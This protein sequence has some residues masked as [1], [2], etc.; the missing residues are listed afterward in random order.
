MCVYADESK[1][2]KSDIFKK[3]YRILPLTYY[4]LWYI[5]KK[6][7]MKRVALIGLGP[8]ARRIY[9]PYL[10][11]RTELG[12]TELALL[13][14]LE[15]NREAIEEYLSEKDLKPQRILFLDTVGQLEPKEVDDQVTKLFKKLKITHAIISTEPKAHKAYLE[16]CIKNKIPVIVDKP[17]VT[18]SNLMSNPQ[19]D[20]K[21]SSYEAAIQI[22]DEVDELY[23][24]IQRNPG[25]RVIVQCQRRQ[26]EGYELVREKLNE[27]V[28]AYNIPISYINIHH[29]DGMWNMPN[30]LY[31]R[32]NHPYKYGYGKIMHSG[33]HFIDLLYGFLNINMQLKDKLPDTINIFNQMLRPIDHYSIVNS[34][35]YENLLGKGQYSLPSNKREGDYMSYGELDSYGQLQLRKEGKV[36][37]TV[38]ISLMQSGFS[39]RAWSTL[40]KDTYKSNGRVRHE[41]VNIHIGPLFNI[42][43]HSYQAV[44]NNE[45]HADSK[46]IGGKDHFDIYIFRNT[47]LIG[48][49][50]F[51][52]IEFGHDEAEEYKKDAYYLGH[53]EKSRYQAVDELLDDLP[54]DSE[55]EKHLTTNAL[56]SAFYENEARQQ[57]D[58]VPYKEYKIQE[59]FY[60]PTTL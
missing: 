54:S 35:D 55:L 10:E 25:S 4:V 34:K 9:Y 3:I 60:E 24:L 53:N 11:R 44:Q 18:T 37:T 38:Q 7:I 49:Q 40:P 36:L 22:K 41:S 39:Q 29:S 56:V 31:D 45:K 28:S 14:D 17:I 26:H 52:L 48:G 5:V 42:Q 8:H 21:E 27:I 47:N 32:E 59:I 50:P 16:L 58:D 2:T 46:T 30:E 23:R 13:V 6:L 1:R 20:N 12:D 57:F 33:Y 51:E 43:V 15:L 19:Y